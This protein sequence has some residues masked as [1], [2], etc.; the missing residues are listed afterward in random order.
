MSKTGIYTFIQLQFS[1]ASIETFENFEDLYSFISN[2]DPGHYFKDG[3][4]LF[5]K[6]T[7][8]GEHYKVVEMRLKFYGTNLNHTMSKSPINKM[9]VNTTLIVRLE[10]LENGLVPFVL[11]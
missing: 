10:E 1:E 3:L 8:R 2:N 11:R 9:P 7:I 5:D 6:L 4:H